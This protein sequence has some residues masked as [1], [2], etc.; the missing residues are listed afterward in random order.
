MTITGS[1]PV[2][3]AGMKAAMAKA[4]GGIKVAEVRCTTTAKTH[5]LGAW[6][7]DVTQGQQS[8]VVEYDDAHIRFIG[9]NVMASSNKTFTVKRADG[10]SFK[11]SATTYKTTK[12]DQVCVPALYTNHDGAMNLAVFDVEVSLTYDSAGEVKSASFGLN[13]VGQSTLWQN[14]TLDFCCFVE[15]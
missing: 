12:P 2:S 7:I 6:E 1:E 5:D 13:A 10:S 9:G 4:G 3:A 14:V 11:T 8:V 15:G